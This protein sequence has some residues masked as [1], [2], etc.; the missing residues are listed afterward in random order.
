MFELLKED[1]KNYLI[2]WHSYSLYTGCLYYIWKLFN[3]NTANCGVM[4]V[5]SPNYNLKAMIVAIVI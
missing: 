3:I 4:C 1:I 2:N 5:T